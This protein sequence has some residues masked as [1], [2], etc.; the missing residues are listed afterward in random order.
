[1]S[2][3]TP[4]FPWFPNAEVFIIR[5]FI[6]DHVAHSS[7]EFSGIVLD[8]GCG[9]MPYKELIMNNPKVEK[10][11]GM[12]LE[13]SDIYNQI[14][15][16]IYWDGYNIP[17]PDNS[18]NCVMLTEVLEHCPDPDK[19]LKEAN[20]VLKSEG[21]IIFSV[22]FIWYLHETPYD[23]Y[24]YTPFALNHIL[25]D[26]GY[27]DID[28]ETYG[29][30]RFALLHVYLI[31]LKRGGAPKVFRFLMYLVTLPFILLALVNYK[32]SKKKSFINGQLYIGIIGSA[33]KA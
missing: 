21:K 3:F 25:T 29:N 30:N 26:T 14:Q 6:W 19:V 10:Y 8:I 33:R 22:P 17:L 27:V 16:D 1:M 32:N 4:R 5:N 12:D 11:L 23:F 15:P 20:R 24:R 9:H 28:L 13:N 18:V 7:R 2:N 31:W